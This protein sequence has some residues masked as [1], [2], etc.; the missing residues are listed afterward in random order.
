MRNHNEKSLKCKAQHCGTVAPWPCG[1][2]APWPCGTVAPWHHGY[3]A[4]YNATIPYLL[5]LLRQLLYLP[6]SPCSEAPERHRGWK[7]CLGHRLPCSHSHG[8]AG[9]SPC[10]EPDAALAV[11]TIWAVSQQTRALSSAF[12]LSLC[13]SYFE[14]K[15]I[16]FL[17]F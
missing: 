11:R 14:N 8:R 4:A 1:T 3:V 16:F 12:F 5:L 17:S 15:Y 2:M 6:S 7:E 9:R 13:D 10:C